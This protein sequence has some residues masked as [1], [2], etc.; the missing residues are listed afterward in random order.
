MFR[1]SVE[2]GQAGVVRGRALT[3]QVCNSPVMAAVSHVVQAPQ[4]PVIRTAV[5]PWRGG[6]RKP[7]YQNRESMQLKRLSQ[8]EN[9]CVFILFLALAFQLGF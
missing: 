5:E 1:F 8:C 3:A 6:G 2:S 9:V 7:V 4:L